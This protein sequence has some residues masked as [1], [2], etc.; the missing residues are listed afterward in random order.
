MFKKTETKRKSFLT[1]RTM[2]CTVSTS[3]RNRLRDAEK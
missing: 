1:G 2:L 3:E